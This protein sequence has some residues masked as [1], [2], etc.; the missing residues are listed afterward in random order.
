MAMDQSYCLVNM[1]LGY[2]MTGETELGILLAAENTVSLKTIIPHENKHFSEFCLQNLP[3][4]VKYNRK[5][6]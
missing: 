2:R 3:P 6:H 4:A 1:H 5:F